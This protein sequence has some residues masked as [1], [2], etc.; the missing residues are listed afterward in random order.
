M[1]SKCGKNTKVAHKAT[2]ECVTD[3]LNAFLAKQY[4]VVNKMDAAS[5]PVSVKRI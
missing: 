1:T 4:A 3:V 2:S 5:L